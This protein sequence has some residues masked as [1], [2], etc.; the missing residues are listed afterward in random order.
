MG[1]IADSDLDPHLD[2]D[3][4]LFDHANHSLDISHVGLSFLGSGWGGSHSGNG[5][6]S[7]GW[8]QN[9]L[10]L[11]T[12]PHMDTPQMRRILLFTL[13]TMA[14]VGASFAIGLT[15]QKNAD[16]T[17]S[18]QSGSSSSLSGIFT[19]PSAP[20]SD[21]ASKICTAEAIAQPG[22]Y[23][24]CQAQCTQAECCFLPEGHWFSCTDSSS[25]VC[26]KYR[27]ACTILEEYDD[28][29]ATDSATST[30]SVGGGQEVEIPSAPSGITDTCSATSLAT[31]DGYQLCTDACAPA[32]CCTEPIETCKVTNNPSACKDYKPCAAL[33]QNGGSAT[34]AVSSYDAASSAG[35]PSASAMTPASHPDAISSQAAAKCN[36]ASLLDA[37]GVQKCLDFCQPALCCFA[38]QGEQLTVDVGTSVAGST[39]VGCADDSNTGWCSQYASCYSLLHVQEDGGFAGSGSGGG[40]DDDEAAADVVADACRDVDSDSCENMCRPAECC[41]V[42]ED[43][44]TNAGLEAL[45]CGH[46]DGCY[47]YYDLRSGSSAAQVLVPRP[48]PDLELTCSAGKTSAS[49]EAAQ[50]CADACSVAKCCVSLIETC[51]VVNPSMCLSWEV[52]CEPVWGDAEFE[53][54]TIPEAPADLES[55]CAGASFSNESKFGQCSD[56]CRP[57]RCCDEDISVCKVTNPELCLSY[58]THCGVVWGDSYEES[59]IPEAPAD[60]EQKCAGALLSADRRKACVDAC[61]PASCCDKD[62]GECKVTN[63]SQ[64][65]PYEVHCPQVWGDAYQQVTVPSAPEELVELCEPSVTGEDYEKCSDLCYQAKCCSEDIEAC[66]VVN[67]QTCEQYEGHCA[68]FW[69]E[70]VTIPYPPSGLDDICSVDSILEADGH[71]KCQSLCD[72]ARCCYDPLDKCRVLNPD[73]CSRYDACSVL[74]S[75]PSEAAIK[76]KETYRGG[77]EIPTAPPGLSD[78]CS[79]KSLSNVHGYSDCEDW[80]NEARC[81]LEDSFECTIL[82]EAACSAYEE[83]C[84]KLFEFKTR[85]SIQSSTEHVVDIMDLAGQ[86]VE[87]CSSSNLK[88]VQGRSHCERLCNDRSCCFEPAGVPES[89]AADAEKECLAFASCKILFEQ[90]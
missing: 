32:R 29:T 36:T 77:I 73:M 22:G 33:I 10:C 34:S 50:R 46:Y 1:R 23:T 70:S 82:N 67:P 71:D 35:A 66:R 83:P 11:P 15:V 4:E 85:G 51:K 26:Q 69:G 45:D 5:G 81:C 58:E 42:D 76:S 14:V 87:A 16:G 89:C 53:E 2:P 64:C 31:Q 54:V 40:N 90:Q 48:P 49:P 27:D 25:K 8:G 75:M 47:E 59:T 78:L 86:V 9:I 63:P 61:R 37:A 55:R 7:G 74:H 57:A 28:S 20:P 43:Y 80:C 30:G 6:V 3:E 62:I 24:K 13:T 60:L 19:Q 21:L 84:T 56:A 52:H 12:L 88:E 38:P 41:F 68:T 17:I 39:I 79:A 72:D 18:G 44:C 65:E